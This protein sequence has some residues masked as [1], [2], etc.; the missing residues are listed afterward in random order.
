MHTRVALQ[1]PR[2]RSQRSPGAAVV[3]VVF[4]GG[5]LAAAHH[6]RR[7][8]AD[9]VLCKGREKAGSG[10]ERVRDGL[11]SS[12]WQAAAV[13]AAARKA[14][15]HYCMARPLTFGALAGGDCYVAVARGPGRADLQGEAA[16]NS[17]WYRSI[18]LC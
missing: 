1:V 2:G 6:A 17:S 13:R 16:E 5:A 4:H 14:G 10:A 15:G 9:H 18:A 12:S 7:V 8:A 11:L 3:D